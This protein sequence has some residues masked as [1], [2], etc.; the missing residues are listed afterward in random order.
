MLAF[1][2]RPITRAFFLIPGFALLASCLASLAHAAGEP[3]LRP[4]ASCEHW[5]DLGHAGARSKLYATYPLDR[6]DPRIRRALIMV[7][8]ALRNPDHYFA[9]A[10]S[11]GFLAGALGDTEI[12]A[13]DFAS[14]EG[15]C[16]DKLATREVSWSC[17][18]TPWQSGGTAAGDPSLSSFDFM[19][20]IIERLG[21]RRRFP[22]LEVIVVAG[23]SA[24]GQFVA[25]YE[26]TNQI[27][28]RLA[29]P[30]RYVVANPSSYAWPDAARPSPTGGAE[31]AAA[32]EAWSSDKPGADY[33]YGPFDDS[34]APGFDR[35]PYGLEDRRVGAAARLDV[36]QLRRNLA[37]RPTTYLLGQVDVLP[38]GGFDD[39][40]KAMAQG[41]TRR[42][43][44]EAF[45][46]RI[47]ETLG[48]KPDLMIVP[49][50]GHNDRC[51]YT[52]ET[53]LP[54]IFPPAGR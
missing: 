39:S 15:E 41:P 44:G 4:L 29:V 14:A 47:E 11:A 40:P 18:G 6:P 31:P 30:V 22:N 20:A 26:M 10:T 48:A 7:H 33:A 1:N 2:R 51:I 54:V 23:H 8:G 9:T 24:G 13:P 37:S 16:Q 17:S 36:D 32:R 53:V 28:E 34:K 19:D 21:D 27:H 50:C 42:A 49:E 5:I 25:R 46:K 38:L 52:T 12:I 43:R 45:V 3:C 35:W